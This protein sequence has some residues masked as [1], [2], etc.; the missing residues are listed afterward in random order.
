[1]TDPAVLPDAENDRRAWAADGVRHAILLR[2]LPIQRHDVLGPLSVLRMGMAVLKR[3][4][5][6][7]SPPIEDIRRRVGEADVQ[8]A[9]AVRMVAA[10]R[11]WDAVSARP[12]PWSEVAD[13][14]LRLVQTS[15]S[16]S[17]HRI[18]PMSA[19]DDAQPDLQ[20][21]EVEAA[22]TPYLLLG[23]LMHIQDT[24]ERPM[25][26]H[27]RWLP[28]GLALH[29]RPLHVQARDGAPSSGPGHA[30]RVIDADAL[31]LLMEG[32]GWSLSRT[33]RD[34]E[35]VWRLQRLA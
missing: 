6:D 7:P 3:R 10:L 20:L 1:M 19:A 5:D 21:D 2:V 22:R 33:V 30:V 24:A 8:V 15:A 14:A 34:D 29:L 11:Q 18:E 31:A 28:A 35:Q 32:S 13:E 25:H 9:E 4:I 16:M 27:A 26:W 17:G 12:R 23:L